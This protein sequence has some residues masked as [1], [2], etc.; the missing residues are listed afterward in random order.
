[1]PARSRLELVIS[2]N[3]MTGTCHDCD[4][5]SMI[6]SVSRADAD[7]DTKVATLIPRLSDP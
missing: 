3:L 7:D 2:G 1:M 4:V 6:A 5:S